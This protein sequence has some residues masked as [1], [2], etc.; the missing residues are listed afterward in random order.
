VVD[1]EQVHEPAKLA[2]GG[3]SNGGLLVGA[4]I[5]QRPELFA[6]ALPGVGVMDMLRFHKFTIGWAWV[7]DYG[8]SEDPAEFKA[9]RAYSPLHNLKA[10][11]EY[12]AT[13]VTTADHDDRVVP[14]HSYKFAAALQAAHKGDRPVMIRIDVK[15]GHGA[16]KPTTKQIEEWADIWGFVADNLGMELG[17]RIRRLR[18]RLRRSRGGDARAPVHAGSRG[19]VSRPGDFAQ[20]GEVGGVAGAGIEGED[21][22][23]LVRME[24]A[25]GG[26]EGSQK[27]ARGL[28]DQQRLFVA[29]E[30]SSP[31]IARS[32]GR[33]DVAAADEVAAQEG[34]QDRVGLVW[35]TG[36][37]DHVEG[38][39]RG[40]HRRASIGAGGA[41]MR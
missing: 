32:Y 36:H 7:S 39:G 21:L 15:A 1:R 19:R 14:G 30:L 29:A 20:P 33:E 13:L 12:P 16:G 27:F 37:K 5:T 10:G 23:H 40:V 22:G 24:L 38:R 34:E 35:R 31:P 17:R 28:H 6:A 2:I 4:A 9:L 41:M 8:S 25:D 3:R 26:E 11:T 18:A